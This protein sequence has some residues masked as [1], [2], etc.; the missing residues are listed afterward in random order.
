MVHTPTH[1]G[2]RAMTNIEAPG[3]STEELAAIA[4]VRPSSIREHLSRRGSYYGLTPRKLPNGRLYWPA[5][6]L[7]RLMS[8]READADCRSA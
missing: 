8:Y 5:D 3:I 2:V 4:Q 6:S 7:D 1:I